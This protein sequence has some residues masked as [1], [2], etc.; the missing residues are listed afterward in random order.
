MGVNQADTNQ[1]LTVKAG[2]ANPIGGYT[3]LDGTALTDSSDFQDGGTAFS[4]SGDSGD[5]VLN[6]TDETA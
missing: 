3:A 5:P 6:G 2:V 4:W 1:Y